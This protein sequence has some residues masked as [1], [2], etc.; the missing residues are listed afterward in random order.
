[1]KYKIIVIVQARLGSTRY[2]GKILEKLGKK[3]IIETIVKRLSKSK[4]IDKIIVATTNNSKDKK[5]INLLKKKKITF[6]KGDEKNV[7]SRYFSLAKK[8][9]PTHIVR[10]CGDCPF[11]D[12]K[13]LD[14]MINFI[15]TNQYDY[16]SNTNPPTF[17][18][19]FDLEIFSYKSLVEAKK[20]ANN[21]FDKE[22][23]TPYIIRNTKNSF[24]LTLKK[25]YSKYRLTIDE[26]RD[27]DVIKNTFEKLKNKSYFD[28]RDVLKVI[29]KFPKLFRT[30][31]FIQRNIGSKISTGQKLWSRAKN[32]IPGGNMLLS[33]RPEM[34]LPNLWP[35]YFSKSKGCHVWD[36]DGKK[37]VDFASMSVGTNIMGYANS[38]IDNAVKESINKGN[39]SSLNCPEEVYL[40]EKLIKMHKSFDMV[41]FAKT[42]GEA[43]SIAIRIARAYSKKDN[44][45]ICGYHGWHDWYLSANISSSKNLNQHL[46]AGLSTSGVPKKL[47][48]TVFPFEYNNIEKF[49]KICKKNN[50][51]AVKME[52]YRNVSPKNNFLK[53]IR[54]FCTKNKIVLIFDECTSGFRETF[55]GLHKKY[56]VIPDLCIFGKALGNGY[57]IT[58]II[59][60]RVIMQSAQSTFISS[61]FWTERTGYVAALKTLEEMDKIKSWEKI[62]KLGKLVKKNWFKSAKQYKLKINITGLDST[63]SFNI[64]SNKWN[65]Y[66]SYFTYRMLKNNILASN[67]I[68]ISIAHRKSLLKKYF[69]ITNKI[70][71]EISIFESGK[72]LKF[73]ESIPECHTGF[74]RLN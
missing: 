10:V 44:V 60:K 22:H 14:K 1:M 28:Y 38:K 34:F 9:K 21:N 33:K 19:G 24:N 48:N 2:P 57:P 39:M 29:D 58:A 56:G 49:F 36:L 67:Y 52:V 61:T 35:T 32:I 15:K 43:N 66:K 64:E 11:S 71:K 69:Q 46:L 27:L 72:N 70:F 68:F 30:N 45:A 47:K 3:T 41:R 8:F 17:P 63:P 54:N 13:I 18:D 42:G 65:K 55:G 73:L 12:Y 31:I 25:D 16:V 40:A 37:Y 5:L 23:V 20:K 50:I 51:G 53:K 59:G 7:L 26:P 6:Y 4:L 62:S 74:K